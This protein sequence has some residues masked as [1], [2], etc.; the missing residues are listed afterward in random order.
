MNIPFGRESMVSALDEG[1][2]NARELARE[3]EEMSF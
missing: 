1:D 2:E 3:L